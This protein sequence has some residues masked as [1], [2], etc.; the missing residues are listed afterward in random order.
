M[1]VDLH[2]N[3][4]PVSSLIAGCS[5]QDKGLGSPI[6]FFP[7]S[8]TSH[9]L[10]SISVASNF[11]RVHIWLGS[12]DTCLPVPDLFPLTWCPPGSSMLPKR[13]GFHSPWGR[14]VFHLVCMYVVFISSPFIGHGHLGCLHILIIIKNAAID[15]GVRIFLWYTD[16]ISFLCSF[17]SLRQ[18]LTKQP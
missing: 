16:F 9:A 17:L 15:M 14:I 2:C 8:P 18:N 12:C 13:M 6:L 10:L 3:L 11:S 1:L 7:H 4:K 5:C